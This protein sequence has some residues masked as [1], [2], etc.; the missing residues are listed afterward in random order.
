M[1][2]AAVWKTFRLAAMLAVFIIGILPVAG[3]SLSKDLKKLTPDDF[4]RLY[5]DSWRA[6]GKNII[7][8]GNAYLPVG[9]MEIFAD[10]IRALGDFREAW[11]EYFKIFAKAMLEDFENTQNQ[12]RQWVK[13][14][15]AI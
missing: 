7:I 11:I 13:D 8:E 14:R 2:Q 4:K 1:V 3:E 12:L 6:S 15:E 5:A 9:N 10:R